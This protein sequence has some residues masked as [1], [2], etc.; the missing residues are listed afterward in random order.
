MAEPT[1]VIAALVPVTEKVAGVELPPFTLAHWLALEAVAHPLTKGEAPE[2]F[3]DIVRAAALC[4]VPGRDARRLA[5]DPRAL[6]SAVD[7]LAERIPP[8]AVRA[9]AEALARQVARAFDTALRATPP[10]GESRSA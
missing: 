3:A 7:E 5:A 2:K 6:E 9:L 1:A 10:E 8:H 4:S